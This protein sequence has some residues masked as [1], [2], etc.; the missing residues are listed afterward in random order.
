VGPNIICTFVKQNKMKF[1]I[2]KTRRGKL[3]NKIRIE[4][5]Q[6]IN[7]DETLIDMILK[8]VDEYEKD[9]LATIEKLRK[10][11]SVDSKRI[12]GALR[13]TINA[14]GPITML[15]IGSATK[16]IHGALIEPSKKKKTIIQ[17]FFNWLK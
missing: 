14:H 7:T 5:L 15:L 12:N 11:K 16:R 10:E 6:T 13:Q 3:E 8:H 2:L 4:I 17:K 1:D 9:N